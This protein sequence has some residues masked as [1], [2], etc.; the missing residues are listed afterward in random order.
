MDPAAAM[1]VV[2][3]PEIEPLAGEVRAKLVGMLE[4]L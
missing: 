1:S 3:N 2:A 4:E